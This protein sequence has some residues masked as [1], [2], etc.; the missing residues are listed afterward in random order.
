MTD[1]QEMAKL[2][3]DTFEAPDKKDL[4]L[5]KEGDSVKICVGKERFWTTVLK[6]KGENIEGSV[7]NDLVTENGLSYGDTIKFEKRHIY[8]IYG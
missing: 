2:N 4:S 3:P 7:D 5:I 6:V 8:S 1:A